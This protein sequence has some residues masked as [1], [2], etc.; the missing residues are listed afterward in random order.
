MVACWRFFPIQ[1]YN[2]TVHCESA[3]SLGC[4]RQFGCHRLNEVNLL[5]FDP[6]AK[7]ERTLPHHVTREAGTMWTQGDPLEFSQPQQTFVGFLKRQ[8][9]G[10]IGPIGAGDHLHPHKTILV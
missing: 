1:R 3:T 4:R 7:E 5:F 6:L 2:R 8:A 9:F 10:Q